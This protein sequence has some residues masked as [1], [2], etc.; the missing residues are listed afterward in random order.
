MPEGL[1]NGTHGNAKIPRL[2]AHTIQAEAN[3]MT[4]IQKNSDRMLNEFRNIGKKRVNNLL[5]LPAALNWDHMRNIS[6]LVRHFL[7]FIYSSVTF[8]VPS[9][10]FVY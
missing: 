8:L 7:C 1:I 2:Y 3:F 5:V 6:N 9:F 4:I 10:K